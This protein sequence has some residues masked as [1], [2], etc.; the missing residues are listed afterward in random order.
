MKI[1][2]HGKEFDDGK[3]IRG[4]CDHCG[5]IVEVKRKEI[6]ITYDQRD[7][8]FASVKCPECGSHI[9]MNKRLLLG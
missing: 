3:P 9:Y 1:I 7:G 6:K 4:K 2:K 8:D 5:C